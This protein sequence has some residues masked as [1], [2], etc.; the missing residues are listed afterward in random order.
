MKEQFKE[1]LEKMVKVIYK[2]IDR[3]SIARGILKRED[4]DFIY[5]EGDISKQGIKK[6]TILRITTK[7]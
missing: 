3:M 6:D 7:E 5:I 1:F 2:D 4:D